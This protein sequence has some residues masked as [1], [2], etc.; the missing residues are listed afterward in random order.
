MKISILETESGDRALFKQRLEGHTLHFAG[1]LDKVPADTEVI[2]IFIYSKMDAAFFDTHPALK[3]IATRSTGYEHIDLTECNRRGI[4]I[5][6]VPSYGD[7]TVAEHTFALILALTRRLR[8]ALNANQKRQF[9]FEALRGI[10]LKHKTLGVI[11]AG[12]VGLHTMK[13]GNAFGMQT[14]AY[15][16]HPLPH[17]AEVLGF[18]YCTLRRV[19]RESDIISLHIP[20]NERT[21]HLLNRKTISN[22]KRGVLLINTA[23][24]ALIDTI[25]LIEALDSGQ[26]GGAGLDVLEDERSMQSETMHLI[27][28][29]IV[30]RLQSGMSATEAREHSSHRVEELHGLMRNQQLLSRSNVIFTP[31]IAFNSV[32]AIERIN[33]CTVENINAF[34]KGRPV[35][36]ALAS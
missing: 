10:E 29:Q 19:L 20:L 32:E 21:H 4:T 6:H 28:E 25:A 12:R 8:E 35:N 24:G 36:V 17:L 23:R 13:L 9:S 5:C 14:I 31:H 27:G 22:C 3:L 16:A 33:L 2:S 1:S 11:G 18:T 7:N 26:V 15:D 30:N 34:A